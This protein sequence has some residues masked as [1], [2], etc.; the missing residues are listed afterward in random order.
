MMSERTIVQSK[1]PVVMYQR[2]E[3]LLFLHWSFD[4]AV[5][6]QTL[7]P[8]LE[9]D[10]FDGRAWLGVVPFFMSGVRPRFLPSVPGI[11]NFQELNLRTYVVDAQGRPGVWFYSLD[12]SHR[13][14]VW[15]AR[16]FFHLNYRYAQMRANREGG[17]IRYSS[18]RRLNSGWDE[19]QA[20]EWT[21]TGEPRLAEQG[22]LEAFL[23]ERYRLF[24]Y[25]S[26]REA[27]FTGRVAHEPYPIQDAKVATHS[28]QLF[29]LS[30]FDQP[31]SEPES[32]IATGGV[33][34][35]IYPLGRV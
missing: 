27:L 31:V 25:D 23:V 20:Y 9:V 26:K 29:T 12:T 34:V 28:K 7:P 14:P 35:R 32:V 6:Q 15:I 10:T 24:A 17:R 18:R 5:I 16:K 3:E 13:L 1:Q 33:D 8:G 21:R 30:K 4:P 2:W 22:S 11:S 19:E